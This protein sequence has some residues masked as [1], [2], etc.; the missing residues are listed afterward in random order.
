MDFPAT[1]DNIA[2]NV[3]SSSKEKVKEEEGCDD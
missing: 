2:E 1:Y 3:C